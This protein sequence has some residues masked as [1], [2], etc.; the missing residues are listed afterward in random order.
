MN[1]KERERE[2]QREN[3]NDIVLIEFKWILSLELLTM[4]VAKMW[5]ELKSFTLF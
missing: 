5:F 1:E 3:V 4:M 2:N